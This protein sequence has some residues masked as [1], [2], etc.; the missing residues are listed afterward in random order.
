MGNRMRMRTLLAECRN[1]GLV[2]HFAGIEMSA[3]ERAATLPWVDRWVADFK[4]GR[5]SR[6]R[7]LRDAILRRMPFGRRNH[8][9]DGADSVDRWM[10]PHWVEAVAMDMWEPYI[11]STLEAVPL[12]SS[13]IVFDR[14]HVMQHMTEAVDVVRRRENRLLTA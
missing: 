2:I 11:Q 8:G 14:F 10:A 3:E 12:A 7:R 5:R 4:P 9:T 13:K 6:L 1:L